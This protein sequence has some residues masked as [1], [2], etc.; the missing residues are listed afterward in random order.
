MA[1]AQTVVL[2]VNRAVS[3][4]LRS[5]LKTQKK[6]MIAVKAGLPAVMAGLVAKSNKKNKAKQNLS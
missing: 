5:P 1:N 2:A 4:H 3:L 6:P